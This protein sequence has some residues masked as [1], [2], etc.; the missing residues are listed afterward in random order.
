[1]TKYERYKIHTI[2]RESILAKKKEKETLKKKGEESTTVQNCEFRF[3]FIHLNKRIHVQRARQT[4]TQARA[5]AIGGAT[6]SIDKNVQT[7]TRSPN[8]ADVLQK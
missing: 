1:M 8:V 4:Q 5:R 3:L 6:Q 2:A 7:Y